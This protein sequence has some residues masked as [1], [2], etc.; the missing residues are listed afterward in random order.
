M[1][2]KWGRETKRRKHLA[3]R[4]AR[5]LNEGLGGFRSAERLPRG[6]G[7]PRPVV[8]IEAGFGLRDQNENLVST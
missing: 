7:S 1:A 6:A 5:K 4:F 8:A 3:E 2:R